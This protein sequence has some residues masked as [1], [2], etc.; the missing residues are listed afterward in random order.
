[1]VNSSFYVYVHRRLSDGLPFYVGKGSGNRAYATRN[2][3][4]HW[5]NVVKKHGLSV[6]IVFDNLDEHTAFQVEK[7]TILEF[8][9]F[10]YPLV[11]LT[12]GGEG[13]FGF[14]FKRSAEDVEQMRL[15]ATGKKQSE[16]TKE[17]RKQTLLAVGTCND[18]NQYVFYSNDDVFIGTRK[19]FCQTYNIDRT[20]IRTLF[21]KQKSKIVLG[22]SILTFHQLVLMNIFKDQIK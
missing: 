5:E 6:E 8:R 18:R 9:Y 14:R 11:N 12:N 7:D 21:N 4:K 16:T 1:M 15:R 3:S 13:I 17:K 20:K 22:W 19:E 2:R 10:N